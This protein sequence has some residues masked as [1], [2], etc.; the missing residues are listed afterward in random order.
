M[1]KTEIVLWTVWVVTPYLT[2][3]VRG[4]AKLGQCISCKVYKTQIVMHIPNM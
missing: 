4:G 3:G 2:P 1:S